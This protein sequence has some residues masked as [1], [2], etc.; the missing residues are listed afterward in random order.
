VTNNQLR[1]LNDI[2]TYLGADKHND[3]IAVGGGK[4]SW[5]FLDPHHSYVRGDRYTIAFTGTL[6]ECEQLQREYE[7]PATDLPF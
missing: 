2:R 1:A 5:R 7:A 3:I 4:W 6:A